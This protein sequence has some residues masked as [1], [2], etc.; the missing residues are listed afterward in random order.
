MKINKQIF[1]L[2]LLIVSTITSVAQEIKGKTDKTTYDIGDRIEFSFKVP[3]EKGNQQMLLIEKP[4]TDSLELQTTRIDTLIENNK[5]YLVYKQYYTSFLSGYRNIGEGVAVKV[6]NSPEGVLKVVPVEIEIL[7]YPIDTTKIEI[8]D[9]KAPL[10]EKFSFKE[11]LPIVYLLLAIIVLGV[12]IYFLM[13]Y[14]SNRKLNIETPE[15]LKEE[16]KIPAH[17]KAL[18]SLEDLLKKRLSEQ[19]LQKQY[20]TELT[21]IIWVYLE[22]RFGIFAS[23][24]TSTQILFQTRNNNKIS[25]ENNRLLE[26][27]FNVSDLVKFAKYQTDSM[28]DNNVFSK[29][30]EF[31]INTKEEIS[32][33]NE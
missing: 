20:Y 8:K 4:N 5:T 28:M 32:E 30:K 13:K 25:Q 9:I 11:V 26:Q 23:E 22:E 33:S 3:L 14:L 7:E 17:I 19:Q 29:A 18:Q 6:N 12:A 27:I 31:V 24:M 21:E 2:I 15:I 10:E 16:P 1:L